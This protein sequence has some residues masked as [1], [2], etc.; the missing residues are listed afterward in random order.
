[1]RQMCEVEQLLS[2]HAAKRP[3]A[4]W[5]L[6]GDDSY[7]WKTALS[8]AY[9]AANGFAALGVRPNTRIGLMAGNSPDF[10]WAYLGA[11]FLGGEVVLINKLQR[12]AAL[13]HMLRDSAIETLVFDADLE[14]VIRGADSSNLKRLVLMRGAS[15]LGTA[16]DDIMTAP[17][18]EPKSE[19]NPPVGAVTLI[20]T[21]GTTGPPKG[22][23][24]STYEPLLQPVIAA[25]EVEPGETMFTC[26]PLF[27]ASGL[28]VFAIGSIR[29]G[30]RLA[31][32][33]AFSAS[34][35]WAD[36]RKYKIVATNVFGVMIPYLLKRPAAADD[37]DHTLRHVLSVGCPPS[38][39]EEFEQRF[40]TRIIEFYGTTD[41]PG[42]LLNKGGPVGSIGQSIDGAEHRIV[43]AQMN[44]MA[45]G[46]V[47]E[48]VYRHPEARSVRYNN[49]PEASAESW[50]GG[51][52][53]S[54]DLGSRDVQGFF[55]FHGR[56]KESIRRKGE[57]ISPWEVA[58]VMGMHPAVM[59]AAIFGVPAAQGEEE[60]MAAIVLKPGAA[61]S[62]EDLLTFCQGKVAKYALPRYIEFVDELPKTSTQKVQHTALKTRG[63]TPAT[64]DR[65]NSQQ[66]AG[67]RSTLTT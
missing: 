30:A 3:D 66:Q 10:L 24:A 20:Y 26:M 64:W 13:D 61:T 41:S 54:G 7:S 56:L 55:Y 34:R 33:E 18:T 38:A 60:V 39:W 15:A 21:S 22:I 46:E 31:L 63:V 28:L 48:I 25:L 16:F 62:P 11:L 53:H 49:L 42:F 52:F 44:D 65:E 12:G 2:R 50:R 51:W 17:D 36:V 19:P 6:F 58:S 4:T 5:L 8:N 1:M 27:H 37:A 57:N 14:D 32:G 35:F 40:G 59:E 43:D 23:V 29:L 47:G 45:A 67:A 9:R